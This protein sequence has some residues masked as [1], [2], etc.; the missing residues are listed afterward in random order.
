M[1][2]TEI[3]KIS[4]ITLRVG[5]DHERIPVKIEWAATDMHAPGHMEECKAMSLALF[6]KNSR[7]TLRIDLWT[8]EMQV[9][10]MDRFIYQILRSLSQTY[11]RATNNRELAEDMARFAHYFGEKTEILPRTS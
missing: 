4:D 6:D 11:L 3:A 10:E 5:L 7:D 1:D 2:R 9:Q 8:N